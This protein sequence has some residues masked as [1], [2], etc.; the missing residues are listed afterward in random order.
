MPVFKLGYPGEPEN[1]LLKEDILMSILEKV[2]ADL[3]S[4]IVFLGVVVLTLIDVIKAT[5]TTL[6]NDAL[7]VIRLK[8]QKNPRRRMMSHVRLLILLIAYHVTITSTQS[9]III[10]FQYFLFSCMKHLGQGIGKLTGDWSHMLSRGMYMCG[11][12][13]KSD[14]IAHTNMG[15]FLNACASSNKALQILIITASV[16]I[17]FSIFLL[18]VIDIA[19]IFWITA[20]LILGDHCQE[21]WEKTN[22]FLTNNDN[23]I[24]SYQ[25]SILYKEF[26][27]D[28]YRTY[29]YSNT[30]VKEMLYDK[31]YIYFSD[32]PEIKLLLN[33]KRQFESRR[34]RHPFFV[35][36]G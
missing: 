12:E 24:F 33:A 35:T 36:L 11:A 25:K 1:I 14:L 4:F 18:I 7:V 29:S 2:V 8:Y 10:S 22:N 15:S 9:H 17:L 19:G 28:F 16:V 13:L 30:F 26:K 21:F 5:I 34:K 31:R 32:D 6:F 3:G 27:G 23:G 20:N